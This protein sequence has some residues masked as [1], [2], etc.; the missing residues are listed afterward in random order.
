MQTERIP[1]IP[2][3][4]LISKGRASSKRPT[5][6]PSSLLSPPSPFG[7]MPPT[8][9]QRMRDWPRLPSFSSSSL[10]TTSRPATSGGAASPSR[11]SKPPTTE[12]RFLLRRTRS[13]SSD[14]AGTQD[15]GN[16]LPPPPLSTSVPTEAFHPPTP[17]ISR[18]DPNPSTSSPP[19]ILSVQMDPLR[20][21]NARAMKAF[22]SRKE[23]PHKGYF[24]TKRGGRRHHA[25]PKSEC[26]Y[27]MACDR[28]ALDL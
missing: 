7:T 1:T 14:V 27:P 24:V 3:A 28:D 10:S 13:N 9:P 26:P 22:K 23:D 25:F 21:A 4:V 15:N 16:A 5:T 2:P 17:V 18:G 11:S 8:S 19:S 20:E 6:S 12:R